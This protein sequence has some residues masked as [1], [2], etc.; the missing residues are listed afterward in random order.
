MRRPFKAST[1]RLSTE[2]QRLAA[3][4]QSLT[5]S[6]SRLEERAIEHQLELGLQKA[7]K[8]G[9]QDTIDS[10][11]N[12]LFKEDVS[13]Y[14]VLLESAEAVSES[15]TMTELV[16]GVETTWQALLV[17]APIC[18]PAAPVWRWRPICIPSTSCLIR[19]PRCMP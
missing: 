9:H 10:T 8:S 6:G 1:P 16:D 5:Q 13:A 14:D 2:A 11:L 7:L 17:S 3:L 18:W 4:A 19:T 12:S 15:S